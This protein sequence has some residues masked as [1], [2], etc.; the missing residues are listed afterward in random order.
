MESST[1]ER[2]AAPDF[3]AIKQRQRATWQAGDYGRIGVTLQIT[4]ESLCEALDLR[5]GQ[6]VLDVAA[7]N[8]NA[9][10]AAARRFCNVV[11]TDYVPTLLEQSRRRA[12]AE[13]LPVDFREADA[14]A[15]PFADGSFDAVLSTFGVMFTPDQRRAA[16]ELQRVCRAGGRIGLAM[17]T[18]DGFIGR[19][20]RVIGRYVAPPPGLNPP[21]AWG[22]R[23]FLQRHFGAGS[24]RIEACSRQFVFRY[25]SPR[26]FLD[27]F[28]TWYG[29]MLK[30][31]QALDESRAAALRDDI[32]QLIAE[33]DIADD[34][35]MKVPSEY[36]EVVIDR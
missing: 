5:A 34:G 2:P 35:T 8:G 7:G 15:L 11:S 12:R 29:P 1:L 32:L 17:W 27:V 23:D 21:A 19:L 6:R 3:A 18:P 33:H 31:F 20:F 4:G 30:A 24:R 25:Q 13:G 10:L 22:T 36:L 26:H 16:D 28:A 9:T 14:E